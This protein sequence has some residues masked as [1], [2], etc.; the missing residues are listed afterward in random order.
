MACGT[1]VVCSG[2][3]SLPE[4]GGDAVMYFNPEDPEELANAI[5]RVLSSKE[6]HL[7]LRVKGLER[8]KRFSWEEFTMKHVELYRRVLGT[9]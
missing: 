1:P 3:A 8:A 4:V 7:S 6:L 2:A 5:E 9:K